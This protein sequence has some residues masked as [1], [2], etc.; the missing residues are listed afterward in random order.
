[1]KEDIDSAVVAVSKSIPRSIINFGRWPNVPSR[2]FKMFKAKECQK[3]L[4]WCVPHILK[5]VNGFT[6]QDRQLGMLLADIAHLFFGSSQKRGWTSKDIQTGRSLLTSWRILSEEY[7]GPPNSSPLKHVVVVR[8]LTIFCNMAHMI[9]FGA[10]CLKDV[11]GL[12]GGDLVV[13]SVSS[14]CVCD[15]SG[16]ADVDVHASNGCG[17]TSGGK[18]LV[19]N[20][21]SSG[22]ACAL[23]GG[24]DVANSCTGGGNSKASQVLDL[25]QILKF[26]CSG[27][28]IIFS[29]TGVSGSG[30]N[31]IADSFAG[32]VDR[33]ALIDGMSASNVGNDGGNVC[34]KPDVWFMLYKVGNDIPFDESVLHEL[35]ADSARAMGVGGRAT[36]SMFS[37]CN[38]SNCVFNV[39]VGKENILIEALD[40]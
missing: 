37:M 9:A 28:S 26:A 38:M 7:E 5:V 24:S 10:L 15:S 27:G 32:D 12:G 17:S 6:V 3:I 21:G 40:K 39:Y 16:C 19:A 30:G 23:A 29:A 18:A 20:F 14:G 2:H 22:C 33:G 35:P 11:S 1:M 4:Q 13:D 31:V 25:V 36:I 34:S 8:Y